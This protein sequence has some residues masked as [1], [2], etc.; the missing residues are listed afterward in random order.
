MK[1]RDRRSF[2]PG[3]FLLAAIAAVFAGLCVADFLAFLLVHW[4]YGWSFAQF[5]QLETLVPSLPHAR[6]GLLLV[7]GVVGLGIG[8][9][10]LVVPMWAGHP[11]R[12]YFAPR[13]LAATWPLLAAMLLIFCA[14]PF[15]TALA[16]WNATL[17]LPDSWHAVEQWMRAQEDQAQRLT[18]AL[19]R[20]TSPAQALAALVVLAGIP[21]VGEEL[22]FR[23]LIQRGLGRWLHS[24]HGSVWLTAAVFSLLHVQFFG[25]VPRFILGVALGYLYLWSDNLLVP[26]A[27]HFAQNAGQLVLLELSQH[28]WLSRQFTPEGVPAWPVALA[29]S[30]CAAGIGYG[31][32]RYFASRAG[33][34]SPGA[35]QVDYF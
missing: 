34:P 7:Q 2:P 18:Q 28:H 11:L 9:G 30:L 1:P 3:L 5:G 14:V 23:G 20:F 35:T 16:A 10:A 15:T 12:R 4:C 29:S 21:A 33:S 25:F 13:P 19:T 26:I 27:A 17:H 24:P 8:L 31:L 32:A 6:A 22:V